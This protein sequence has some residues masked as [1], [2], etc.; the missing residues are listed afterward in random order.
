MKIG[1]KYALWILSVVLI[2]GLSS[3]YLFYYWQIREEKERLK[4][5]GETAGSIVEQGLQNYMLTKD[6][7]V[8]DE[9]LRN[10]A[11]IK[12]LS[13]IWL[14]NRDGVVKAATEK[15]MVDKRLSH[16]DQQGRHDFFSKKESTF[17]W[18]QPVANKPECHKCHNPSIRQNGVIIIDFSLSESEKNVKQDILRG[19]S[20]FSLSVITILI[21][22]FALTNNLVIK[23]LNSVIRRMR[24]FKEGDFEVQTS[25]RRD[26]EITRL[27][28]GFNEMALSIRQQREKEKQLVMSERFVALGQMASGIAHEINNPLA[29]IAGCAE[30]LHK[31]LREGKYERELFENYLSI[32]EEEIIRCKSITTSMLSFV[33]N[34]TD[35]ER[36]I[37]VNEVIDRAVDSLGRPEGHEGIEVIRNGAAGIPPVYGNAGELRQA[38]MAVIKNAL[39][40]MN[41]RGALT[42]DSGVTGIGERGGTEESVIVK[43]GDTGSGISRED[44]GKIFDPFFTTRFERGHVGLGLSIARKIISNHGGTIDVVSEKDKGTVFTITLP[45]QRG[46]RRLF[47]TDCA[48]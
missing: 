35:E 42:I 2:S 7:G 21:F 37:D 17:R 4:A 45:A 3:A 27:E 22:V 26:D 34:S 43:I 28:E 18:V 5:F 9:T 20:I 10:L 24:R 12:S 31:R 41:G 32:I 33:R 11:D 16:A 29:A 40:A 14:V 39:D 47:S 25:S 19:F 30:G 8:L 13:R 23:R 46:N 44:I 15:D 38:F 36:A 1:R 48:G 6:S